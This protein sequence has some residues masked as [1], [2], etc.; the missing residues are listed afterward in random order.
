MTE[1]TSE[2]FA[3][4]DV[5]KHTLDLHLEGE[6][7]VLHVEY[8]DAGLQQVCQRLLEAAPTLIVLEAT[9]G[10]E[11][12]LAAELG[13]HGLPVAVVNPRQ[14]R[15]F[16]KASGRLA[17][18]DRVDAQVLSAF[19]R[20]IR[21]AARAPKEEDVR[22]LE[23]LVTRRRQL[24]DIRVQ[25]VLRLGTAS[26]LQAK[27]LK[28]HIAWLDRR[29]AS[30]DTDLTHRLRK[31]EIWRAK[32]DLLKSIPGVGQVTCMT[33]LA[34]CPELGRLDRREIAA[35]VGVAPLAND[36][37]T[38]RGKRFIWG[39]RAD[40]RAVLYMAAVSAMRCNT[41]IKTFAERLKLA[42]KPGKVVI[43]ACMRK[44]L[45]IMNSILKSN[46]PW[47]PENACA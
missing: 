8:D 5:S 26:K 11:T 20:A 3:G 45:T 39:G 42:G 31:S 9:G 18:T 28:E 4:V 32:E 10:L 14:V 47:N 24:I 2:R 46:T 13:A 27:S 44:L 21:P 22:E 38:H 15:D 17:K 7:D 23:A 41:I 1:I 6:R 33:L 40:V 12:R 16:A 36:S 30:L 25:E 34:K 37:G 29:I 35:L 19:A 43:V